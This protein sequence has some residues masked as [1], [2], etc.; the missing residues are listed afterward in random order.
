M[1]LQTANANYVLKTT[2]LNDL[3]AP[4]GNLSLNNQKITGLQT[5]TANNDA[6]NKSY[7]DTLFGSFKTIYC[8]IGSR[9]SST[10][11][12]NITTGVIPGSITGYATG[13][14]KS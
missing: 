7:V 11:P 2:V 12:V 8:V 10:T 5:P 1:N 9:P 3:T 6:A 14:T 4:T 13:A